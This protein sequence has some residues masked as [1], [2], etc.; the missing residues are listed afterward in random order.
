VVFTLPHRPPFS[1]DDLDSFPQDGNRYE[2]INGDLHVS[3]APAHLHQRATQNLA[4]GLNVVKPDA[5]EVLTGPVDI[6]L[7]HRTVVEPD[8][9]VITAGELRGTR[10][11]E[12]PLLVI[13]VLSPSNRLYDLGTKQLVYADSAIPTLWMV[14]PVEPSI[15]VWEW[16]GADEVVRRAAGDEVLRLD[17]PFPVAFAPARLVELNGWRS[18]SAT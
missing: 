8:I 17:R 4:T 5:F 13:E 16:D 3:A 11:N 15:T 18:I 9:V 2:L 10:F 12:P 6:V 7:A 1:V 14:D